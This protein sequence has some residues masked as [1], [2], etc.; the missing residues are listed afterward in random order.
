M[1]FPL[2]TLTALFAVYAVVVLV[3]LLLV[4]RLSDAVG[5]QIGPAPCGA[6][7]GTCLTAGLGR[8]AEHLE[9]LTPAEQADIA[10]AVSAVRRTRQVTTL[11]MPCI[12]Q[13]RDPSLPLER[14]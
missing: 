1:R 2:S 9:Q 7:V 3:A 4:G 11:G 13:S 10:T 5:P 12:S 8:V 14:P 6:L